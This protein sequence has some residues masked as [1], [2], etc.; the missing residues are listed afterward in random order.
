MP[1]GFVGY[2]A[3]NYLTEAEEALTTAEATHVIDPFAGRAHT[4]APLPPMPNRPN[5]EAPHPGDTGMSGGHSTGV[6]SSSNI[7]VSDSAY[8]AILQTV[9]QTDEQIGEGLYHTAVSIEEMCGQSYMMPEC[10]PRC[11]DIATT[12]KT[13]MNAF[14]AITEDANHGVRTF[15]Q[16]IMAIG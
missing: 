5:V 9:D 11:L 12:V 13:S 15:K 8:S 2:P 1:D 4:A 3:K 14:R 10:T 7:V 6:G 16:A